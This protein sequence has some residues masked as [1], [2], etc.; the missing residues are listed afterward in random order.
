MTSTD[1][2]S[3]IAAALATRVDEHGNIDREYRE[4]RNVEVTGNTDDGFALRYDTAQGSQVEYHDGAE[5]AE[6]IAAKLEG[7]IAWAA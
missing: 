1:T 7:E 2:N 3:R 6:D 5:S 4:I